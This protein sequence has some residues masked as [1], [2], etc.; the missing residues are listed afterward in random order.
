[1]KFFMVRGYENMEK[2][3]YKVGLI[4]AYHYIEKTLKTKRETLMTFT[5]EELENMDDLLATISY[6][7]ATFSKEQRINIERLSSNKDDFLLF[8][9]G[10]R[11][12][13]STNSENQIKK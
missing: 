2:E 5:I 1:M 9:I 7:L 11:K 12:W 13:V 3:N 8:K 10:K 6:N 4:E